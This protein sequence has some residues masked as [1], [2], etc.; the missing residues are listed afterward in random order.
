MADFSEAFVWALHLGGVMG[1]VMLGFCVGLGVCL[2]VFWGTLRAAR[3]LT[4]Y[5]KNWRAR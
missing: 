5:L 1:A 4:E 3:P 2:L